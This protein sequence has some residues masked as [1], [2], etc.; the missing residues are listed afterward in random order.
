MVFLTSGV[1]SR[2]CAFVVI[3]MALLL[4]IKKKGQ[5]AEI[6]RYV[7]T[8]LRIAMLKTTIVSLRGFRGN[9]RNKTILVDEVSFNMIPVVQSVLHS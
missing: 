3:R 1:M 6:I 4:E 2:K 8:R 9:Q 7:R 5:Y